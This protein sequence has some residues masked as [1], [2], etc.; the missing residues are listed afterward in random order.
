[1]KQQTMYEYATR[2]WPVALGC[3]PKMRCAP[4]CWAVRICNRLAHSPNPKV[5]AAHEGLVSVDEVRGK[6]YMRWTGITRL[7]EAHLLDP[8]K[9]RTPQRVAVGYHGDLF[10]LPFE[11]ILRAYRVM[12]QAHWH[13]YFVLTKQPGKLLDFTRWLAGQDDISIAEWPR[14]C[15]LGVSVEDQAAADERIPVL[16][17]TPAA[18][19]WVS[20]EPLIAEVS[21]E[22]WL[23]PDYQGIF[24]DAEEH[25]VLPD[26]PRYNSLDWIVIGG[27]SGPRAR[28]CDLAWIR[29][30]LRQC[31]EAGVP[32]FVKQLGARPY[33]TDFSGAMRRDKTVSIAATSEPWLQGFTKVHT[34]EGK[35]QK[36]RYMRLSDPKGANPE[37]WPADLRV[38]EMPEVQS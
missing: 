10:R 24:A 28:P 1:M 11:D 15:W 22:Q 20:L 17:Q 16:L 29:D 6:T 23:Q 27:E 7:N 33:D 36:I 2:S 30:I 12:Q 35:E 13:T 37:E 31:R 14:Q 25:P 3:S 26:D 19:R 4:R 21:I 5:R 38:R 9:W 8:L 32:P 18:H 34:P